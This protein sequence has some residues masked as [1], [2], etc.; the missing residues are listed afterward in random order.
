MPRIRTYNSTVGAEN[1]GGA[2]RPS[3]VNA[4]AAASIGESRAKGIQGL[5]QPIAEGVK[6]FGAALTQYE[7]QEE[8]TKL[9]TD[10]TK[11]EARLHAEWNEIAKSPEALDDPA[12][13][14]ERFMSERVT[15]TLDGIGEGLNTRAA[16][17]SFAKM[18][19]SA[20][21]DLY[22]TTAAD[23]ST[24][25]GVAGQRS[26]LQTMTSVTSA[27][28]SNPSSAPTFLA[29]WQ[30]FVDSTP[31]LG[32]QERTKL[33]LEGQKQIAVA[34]VNG[35]ANNNPDAA[36]A[37][38]DS[39]RLDKFLD[40]SD[41]T[42]LSSHITTLKNAERTEARAQQAEVRRQQKEQFDATS[43]SIVNSF[44]RTDESGQFLG[45]TV[46]P[47]AA[48]AVANLNLMPG[49][50][51]GEARA[52]SN[53]MESVIN[54]PN[55][56]SDPITYETMRQKLYN[57]LTM[58]EVFQSR[59]ENR[60]SNKDFTFFHE[61]VTAAAQDPLKTRHNQDFSSIMDGLKSYVGGATNMFGQLTK[62]DAN[63]AFL[64]FQQEARE[65]YDAEIKKGTLLKDITPQ[66]EAIASKWSI[67]KKGA[68][69]ALKRVTRTPA[70]L[71]NVAKPG[72]TWKPGMSIEELDRQL[73]GGK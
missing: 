60:L 49:A 58:Q 42:Q 3:G 53:M 50:D 5:G 4:A 59:A 7:E 24:L 68:L 25:A 35:I 48:K 62:P 71:P 37:E 70:V 2:L 17:L 36:Q 6:K 61:A 22:K 43:A 29:R 21:G 14:A 65:V 16:R 72:I 13:T 20:E 69:D 46:P 40:A 66:I 12:G 44:I 1:P 52:M 55:A 15:P 41:K 57:G 11:E 30:D 39:G 18:R 9:F 32:P 33:L 54:N 56:Q 8:T 31:N 45:L 64:H 26:V 19:A 27:A 34:Q 51:G 10:F 67:D 73:S 63:L 28:L 23:Q 47:E 38:L